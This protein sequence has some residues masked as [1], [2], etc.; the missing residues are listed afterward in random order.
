MSIPA[1]IKIK[2]RTGTSAEW[3]S[4]NP[5]LLEGEYGYITDIKR[6]IIGNGASPY[7]N[8]IDGFHHQQQ[9]A[10][11]D[12]IITLSGAYQTAIGNEITNRTNAD[13][14]LQDS[15][16]TINLSITTISG[17]VSTLQSDVST[18]QGELSKLDLTIT[19]K[20]Q[21][22]VLDENA[23]K[24]I[25]IYA[26]ANG[27]VLTADDTNSSG[28]SWSDIPVQSVAL[29]DLT[30]VNAP[31]P[32][33]ND[34]LIYD[35]VHNEWINS[36]VNIPSNIDDLADVNAPSPS[37]NDI[38]KYNGT[39]WINS[40]P[41]TYGDMF[42]ST[43]DIDNDGIVDASEKMLTI[44]RNSTGATLY[45]GIIVYI[46]GS[47]GNRPNFTKAQANAESTSAGTF[48]VVVS[49]I[50]NNSDGY[51][52]TIGT[53][54]NLDTR[55]SATNP[56]TDVTLNDGD[57]IY[58]H[59]TIAGYITNVKP[60]AP[61]HLVYVGKVIRT[62]PNLGTIVYRIHN[63]YELKELHDVQ[64]NSPSNNDTLYYDNAS[65]Q[66]KTNSIGGILGYT[67]ANVT[68][69]V[70]SVGATS[71]IASSGGL[72]PTISI[73]QANASTNGYLASSDFTTFNNKFTGVGQFR[74]AGRWYNNGIFVPFNASFTNLLN[75]IRYVPVLIDSDVTITRLGINVVTIASAGTTCRLG[76]YTNDASTCQPLT[77]LVDSGTL[78]LDTTGAKSVTGLSVALTKGL[79][80]L[81]YVSNVASGTITGLG[82]NFILDVKGQSAI[83]GVGFAGFNQT[84]T[85]GALPSTAGTLTEVNGTGT[86]CIF[87]YY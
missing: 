46:S 24:Y 60:S 56:F 18:I 29:D 78:A 73:A 83:G 32:S 34:F 76:I 74:K 42:K 2:V 55:T 84:F 1:I 17:N 41:A 21:L 85:Y 7:L 57:T 54:H 81:A 53:L 58:L 4:A 16:D 19:T 70:T 20:G 86:I 30:D 31:S 61:N 25:P 23:G 28:V 12:D 14:D 79:Y 35:G 65:S 44:G 5:I 50:A 75:T 66:W 26:G 22:L 71:P 48:G 8:L 3:T 72:A 52:C 49:D 13:N 33:N 15:I 64:A 6:I 43:Y 36:S 37:T 68:N 77:R 63:G 27:Q 69:A 10:N 39:E 45:Q 38:L 82:T 40:A 11:Y 51:V 47:T 9:I 80:W 59:P 67:P 87:Y 62:H